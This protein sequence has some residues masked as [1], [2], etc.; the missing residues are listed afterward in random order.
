MSFKSNTRTCIILSLSIRHQLAV[1]LPA[2]DA[3]PLALDQGSATSRS[4]SEIGSESGDVLWRRGTLW[5]NTTG[6]HNVIER[7]NFL[8]HADG[9]AK[10]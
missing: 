1:V 8:V 9:L 10:A 5:V 3:R 7:A 6:M 2:V 4:L